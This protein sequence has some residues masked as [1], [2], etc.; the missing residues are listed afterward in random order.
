LGAIG[1]KNNLQ[2]RP[3]MALDT[4][5]NILTQL[6]PFW[7]NLNEKSIYQRIIFAGETK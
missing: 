1:C 2:N 3:Q 4:T 5:K 6:E 7:Y